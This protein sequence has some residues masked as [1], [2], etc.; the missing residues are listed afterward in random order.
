MNFIKYLNFLRATHSLRNAVLGKEG[1]KLYS[2]Y[3]SNSHL[4]NTKNIKSNLPMV[5]VSFSQ[6]LN[7]RIFLKIL[8]NLR[9]NYQPETT[10]K[11]TALIRVMRKITPV[12]YKQIRHTHC[13]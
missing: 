7:E 3:Y 11:L 4:N 2:S 6:F 10:Q 12:Y 5:F 13:I 1:V 8:F 9:L